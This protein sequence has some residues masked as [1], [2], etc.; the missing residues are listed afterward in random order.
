MRL[1]R[2]RLHVL[3]TLIYGLG[4]VWPRLAWKRYLLPNGSRRSNSLSSRAPDAQ[5]LPAEKPR[6]VEARAEEETFTIIGQK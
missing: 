4:H 2:E 5:K 3:M 6:E 1:N